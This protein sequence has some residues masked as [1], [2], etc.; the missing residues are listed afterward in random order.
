MNCNNLDTTVAPWFLPRRWAASTPKVTSSIIKARK[1]I[2]TIPSEN[3]R[4]KLPLEPW[5][6][7]CWS[8]HSKCV[9]HSLC[10]QLYRKSS[11]RSTDT[12]WTYH[13][14]TKPSCAH[15]KFQL[16]LLFCEH[17]GPLQDLSQTVSGSSTGHA[18]I[19]R[20]KMTV[21]ALKTCIH[22]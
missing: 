7:F 16:G 14:W 10:S 18:K 20:I 2:V 12:L 4:L 5:H 17:D 21:P 22:H 13:V 9:K 15:I 8:Y 1:C 3:T 19:M 6:S 11:I